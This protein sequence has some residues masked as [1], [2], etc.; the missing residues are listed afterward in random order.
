MSPI[1][2]RGASGECAGNSTGMNWCSPYT[3]REIAHTLSRSS[4]EKREI[5]SIPIPSLLLCT[6]NSVAR[7]NRDPFRYSLDWLTFSYFI[8]AAPCRCACDAYPQPGRFTHLPV[9]AVTFCLAVLEWLPPTWFQGL[10]LFSRTTP[11][12]IKILSSFLRVLVKKST[13]NQSV[14]SSIVVFAI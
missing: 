7:S 3:T 4:G 2:R 5:R 13:D 8:H 10:Q 11:R 14:G 12:N 1:I 6:I 9:N